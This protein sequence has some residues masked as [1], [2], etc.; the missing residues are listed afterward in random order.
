MLAEKRTYF[1]LLRTGLAVFS[2][3]MTIIVFIAATNAYHHIFNQTFSAISMSTALIFVAS[4]GLLMFF[5]AEVKIK[6][7]NAL[8]KEVRMK[9]KIIDRIVV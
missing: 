2:V 9:N 1:S 4:I 3:P 7:L 5:Q 6:H 8:I